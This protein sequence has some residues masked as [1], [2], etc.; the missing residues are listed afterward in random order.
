M[1]KK[2]INH[3]VAKEK[4]RKQASLKQQ[5]AKE[6]ATATNQKTAKAAATKRS[7]VIQPAGNQ[8]AVKKR[9]RPR[10]RKA[11]FRPWRLL[12]R[13]ILAA[14][15]ATA[16]WCVYVLWLV[17]SYDVKAEYPSA[18]AGIV[19]GAALWNDRPSP[20]LRERLDLAKRLYEDG[21]VKRLILSGGYGGVRSSLSEAE[22]MRNYLVASGVPEEALL[23]EDQAADTYQNLLFSH[24]VGEKADVSSYLIITHDYHATRAK[25]MAA[26]AGL[27]PEDVAAV[28]SD[29][30]NPY[31]NNTRE[32]L[33]YSKWKLDWLLM[34]LG[35]LT[36]PS[37]P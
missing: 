31:Y 16:I 35:I 18:D 26:N 14:F 9:S 2:A 7:S 36:P 20:A 24:A 29:V 5:T 17:G 11:A 4:N 1:T 13:L 37:P 8:K 15:T 6:K 25:E 12:F 23:L 34:K 3:T 21:T 27:E 19:L 30:L 28:H 22:G 33:A 32:M 10:R